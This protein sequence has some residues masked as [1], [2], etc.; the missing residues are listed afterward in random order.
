M[1]WLGGD[2][3]RAGGAGA[4]AKPKNQA[5][6]PTW[7]AVGQPTEDPTA[8]RQ[9]VNTSPRTTR[10]PNTA[11]S[12]SEWDKIG[13]RPGVIS[14]ED[15]ANQ[16]QGGTY[17]PTAAS[18]FRA[19]TILPDDATFNPGHTGYY[20]GN[21]FQSFN[22][23]TDTDA[24]RRAGYTFV[25]QSPDDSPEGR[26]RNEQ[27]QREAREDIGG[28]YGRGGPG[29]G[30]TPPGSGGAPGTFQAGAG[31]GGFNGGGGGGFGGG[32]FGGFMPYTGPMQA[33]YRGQRVGNHGMVG[34]QADVGQIGAGQ[35][36]MYG[37]GANDRTRSG[38]F[39]RSV[40]PQQQGQ[41]NM[42]AG[43]RLAANQRSGPYS[44]QQINPNERM[45]PYGDAARIDP[46]ERVAPSQMFSAA[47]PRQGIPG[48]DQ[49]GTDTDR[50]ESA[51][52]ER[53]MNNMRPGMQQAAGS[54]AA[55]ARESGACTWE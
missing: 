37:I 31:Q 33:S 14:G 23:H 9:M 49:F 3:A 51:T 6:A 11:G 43:P 8:S 28:F 27:Q 45:G 22:T 32:G 17:K 10:S 7:N 2:S 54:A 35:Q 40:D 52:Y 21:K 12:N 34:A 19:E 5:N 16:L 47:D 44:A 15:Y 25:D 1:S 29:Y 36:G 42:G 48:I 13:G 53:M 24:M 38:Q 18:G 26:A 30:R 20:S 55:A 41:F 4:K 50:M 46:N 39:F